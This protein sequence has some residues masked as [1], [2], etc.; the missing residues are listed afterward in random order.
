MH[1][2]IRS[3]LLICSVSFLSFS[4]SSTKEN[5]DP[6]E[7]E[8]SVEVSW[9][10]DY[11]AITFTNQDDP[12][13]KTY[14]DTYSFSFSVNDGYEVESVVANGKELTQI[15]S[16]YSFTLLK[17]TNTVTI[18]TNGMDVLYLSKLEK[19]ETNTYQTLYSNLGYPHFPSVGN[20]NLLVV[21]VK[22]KG[23][24][25]YAT[26]ENKEKLE[27]A[28]FGAENDVYYES[29]STFYKKSSYGN[30]NVSGEVTD[31]FDLGLTG[32]EIL[33]ASST[34]YTDYGT[35]N[36]LNKAIEWVKQSTSIDLSKYDSNE[37]GYIDGVYLVYGA[38]T[39]LEDTS[40][41][42][43]L[44]WNFTYYNMEN[45]GKA[46]K[47]NLLPMTYS[48]S[49]VDMLFNQNKSKKDEKDAHA[50]IHEFGHQLGLADY[51]DTDRTSTVTTSPMG[52]LD[53]MD[54]NIGDHSPFSKF[55]L[56]WTSPTVLSGKYGKISAKLNY[57]SKNGDF[58]II[59]HDDYN[60]LPFDEYIVIEYLK[61]DD[62]GKENLNNYDGEN[63]Y[64]T[65]A[66]STGENVSYFLESGI[67]VTHIDARGV[68]IEDGKS[69]Y[70][71]DIN[72]MERV[73]FS[74]T[75]TV[76]YSGYYDSTTNNPYVL[77]TLISANKSRN[78]QGTYFTANS[79]DLF[80]AGDKF[81]FDTSSEYSR[82][83]MMPSASSR[84][85]NGDSINLT[86]SIDEITDEYA[87]IS[88]SR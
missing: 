77:S 50:F 24:E 71:N 53:M 11:D 26:E 13:T 61:V 84:F 74:N 21:P 49:S 16:K 8:T 42:S 1:K 22:I 60:G 40:L 33:E 65:L 58:I 85:N 87:T 3:L 29:L 12:T 55:A 63:P 80:K 47:D 17:G 73:K 57:F 70:T 48:W 56:G 38:P 32:D 66:S 6:V 14:G 62:S 37:D 15:L 59:T 34:S 52:G 67:R 45:K 51:Y 19:N 10:Y 4:C 88:I 41:T 18:N 36:V 83:S 27:A 25:S 68:Y 44:F 43:N 31:W 9:V 46:S 39:I 72:K 20:Q 81:N 69:Y 2:N 64:P 76:S 5:N 7:K 79:S 78:V 30:L 86:V 75:G 35:F 28:F 23:Y 82:A 54:Y